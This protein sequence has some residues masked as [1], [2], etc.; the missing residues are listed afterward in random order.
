MYRR[1]R[2]CVYKKEFEIDSFLRVR[3]VGCEHVAI[4]VCVLVVFGCE[5]VAVRVPGKNRVLNGCIFK[6][7]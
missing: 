2:I 5:Y 3:V 7:S 4:R 6:S 1:Q